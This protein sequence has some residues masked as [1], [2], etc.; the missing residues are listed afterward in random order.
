MTV[1]SLDMRATPL[2]FFH[3]LAPDSTVAE[4][5]ARLGR[6]GIAGEQ[7]QQVM[8]TLSDGIKS[9]VVL[10]LMAHKTPHILLLDEPTNNLD[11]ESIDALGEAI[12]A[13]EG[14]VV[15]VSHDARLIRSC[16]CTLWVC[17][18]QQVLPFDGDIDDYRTSLIKDIHAESDKLLQELDKMAEEAEVKRMEEMRKRARNL[19][20]AKEAAAAAA[21]AGGG[22]AGH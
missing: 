8:E 4:V 3:S 15:L 18:K 20:A 10:A 2:N 16:G 12:S 5:R 21:A 6:F 19:K 17:D 9:R 1:D 11:I 13:Y 22:G 7:Q 14:G